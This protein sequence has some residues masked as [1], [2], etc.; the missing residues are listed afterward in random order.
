MN[1]S[2][3]YPCGPESS[4]K[5]HGHELINNVMLALANT[6]LNLQD[7]SERSPDNRAKLSTT[8]MKTQMDGLRDG[9]KRL[10]EDETSSDL[11]IVCGERTWKVHKFCLSAQSE[12]FYSA[13]C[14]NF[15]EASRNEIALH[16]EDP[17]VLDAFLYYLYHF[18][19]TAPIG[20]RPSPMEFHVRVYVI[21]D[22]YLVWPL[23]AL[24][25]EKFDHSAKVSWGSSRFAEAVLEVYVTT[26]AGKE[27]ALKQSL[28]EVMRT[29]ANEFLV[30]LQSLQAFFD[31]GASIVKLHET[32]CDMIATSESGDEASMTSESFSRLA[33]LRDLRDHLAMLIARRR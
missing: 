32:I 13:C 29:Q 2:K 20:D 28:V 33:K 25:A 24:A 14:G 1:C 23:R 17:A 27:N 16:E 12:F 11:T 6:P 18:D 3:H 26:E 15:G 7:S 9:M 8:H 22:K 30:P 31:K 4:P 10:Y 19:Y 21:A 5:S